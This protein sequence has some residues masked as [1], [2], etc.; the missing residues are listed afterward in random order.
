MGLFSIFKSSKRVY[1]PGCTTYF[2]HKEYFDL[3]LRILSRLGIEYKISQKKICCGLPALEL[4][5]DSEARKIA[6]RNFEIFKEDNIGEIITSDPACYKMFSLDY[7]YLLPDWNISTVNIWKIILDRLEE[8]PGL[9]KNKFSEKVCFQDSCYLS[10]YLGIVSEPRKIL[11]LLGYNLIEMTDSK[12]RSI[13]SGNC[14]QLPFTN[15]E[16]AD[17]IAK[18][19][20]LQA[21]R[22]GV[23]KI[24]TVSISDYEI[25]KRNSNGI[26][27]VD[28]SEVLGEC[29]GIKKNN[30]S[31]EK[32]ESKDN[33]EQITSD[34]LTDEEELCDLNKN[35]FNEENSI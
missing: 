25:L 30:S 35:K 34:E 24:I 10:R 13:C 22:I 32:L 7:P 17:L 9:I 19:R 31:S 27:V 26:E 28:I 12:E 16:L 23:Q 29:L 8:K 11:G 21:K 20:I 1:F 4:G 5:Y 18:E 3:Y 2:K 15:P 33:F 6:R 14:G